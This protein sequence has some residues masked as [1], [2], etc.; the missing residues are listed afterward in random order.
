MAGQ[1]IERF[2]AVGSRI[3]GGLGLAVVVLVA[4]LGV[5]GAGGD[6]HPAVYPVCGLLGLLFWATMIRPRVVVNGDDLHLHGSFSDV[7]VP[8]AAVEDVVVRQWL[9]VQVG[10]QSF[11]TVG[12]S[13]SHRQGVRDDRKGD[14]TFDKSYG[15]IVE[16]RLRSLAVS[17]RDRQ[18]VRP[19]SAEQAALAEQVRRTPARV[20][21]ALLA[22]LGVALAVTLAL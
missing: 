9:S 5:T 1:E 4:L 19:D 14:A 10:G 3:I 13:R 15:A 11:T 7:T 17:A 16:A 12:V 6:Y 22:V 18:G 8:L 2:S 20:E 21:L